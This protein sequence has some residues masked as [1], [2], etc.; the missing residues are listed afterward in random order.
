MTPEE[1]DILRD[2]TDRLMGDRTSHIVYAPKNETVRVR[3]WDGVR[4]S[5]SLLGLDTV[6]RQEM[7]E[8]ARGFAKLGMDGQRATQIMETTL[9][10]D[11]EL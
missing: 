10:Y 4:A 9:S 2:V 7:I 3:R 8:K 1:A 11:S 5:F 6:E